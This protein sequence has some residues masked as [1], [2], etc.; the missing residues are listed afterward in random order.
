MQKPKVVLFIQTYNQ[1]KYIS[2]SLISAYAQDYENLTIYI[3]DDASTDNTASLI[4]DFVRKTNTKH[5]I[6]VRVNNNN[7]GAVMNQKK[8]MEE[9]SQFA[10]FVV[11]Q[12][13]DDASV[14]KRVSTLT[15]LWIS[16]GAPDFLYIH[17]PVEII[18]QEHNKIW[19]PPINQRPINLEKIATNPTSCGLTIGASSAYTPKMI[20]HIPLL[21]QNLYIDQVLTFRSFFMK[22][23][24]YWGEP[25]LKYRFGTGIS[26]PYIDKEIYENKIIISTIDTLKQRKFD[27]EF[28]KMKDIVEKISK[29]INKWHKLAKIKN[30]I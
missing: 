24:I 19:M 16:L 23:L 18:G 20:T 27:A 5:E 6:I 12:D 1:E 9:I 17:T 26:S 4:E 11:I 28:Y 25:L 3:S 29:E 14:P 10:N 13:G 7:V 2:E 15:E 8:S 21:H 22:K 30:L